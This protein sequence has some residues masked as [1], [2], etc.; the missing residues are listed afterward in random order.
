MRRFSLMMAVLALAAAACGGAAASTTSAPQQDPATT[1][2]TVPSAP[3]SSVPTPPEDDTVNP[4]P[5]E[6]TPAPTTTTT[7]VEVEGDP[8]PDFA[9]TLADGSE[10]TLSGEA[11]PA[12]LVFWAEWCPTCKRELPVVDALAREYGDQIA[13]VAVAGKSDLA[14]TAAEAERLFSPAIS[15][16]LDDSIWDLYE[17]PYQPASFFITGNDIVIER[18]AGPVSEDEMRDLFDE[19]IRLAG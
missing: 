11:R 8:A 17:V 15:W 19:L 12:Y 14:A 3:T 4:G 7:L 10:F 2:S 18:R 13:F 1:S 16:G 9:L 5:T 6:T